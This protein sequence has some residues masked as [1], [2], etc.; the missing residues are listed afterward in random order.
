MSV[1]PGSKLAHYKI[2]EKIGSG[3]MGDV[4]LAEDTKLDRKVAL[5]VLPPELAESDERRARFKREAKAIA[6]LNHPNI[7]TIYSVEEAEGVHFLTME[8]V[9]G[10]TL[11]R[12]IPE[13]G[14][15]V[16]RLLDI[17]L[18]LADAV[19]AAHEQDIVHRD[20][21]PGNVMLSDRGQV[22]VFDFGLARIGKSKTPK[23]LDSDQST[24][25]ATRSGVVLGTVPYMSPEQLQG[26]TVDRRSD[27]FS[28]GAVLYQ[29]ATGRPP[30]VGASSAELIS[31]I[32]R[33]SP[34]MI[35]ELRSDVPPQL[36]RI[37]QR[38]LEK[39]TQDRFSTAFD[40][41][42]E[43]RALRLNRELDK[44][45]A[46]ATRS[47]LSPAVAAL[48]AAAL[49]GF[50]W[51][52]WSFLKAPP[53]A[54]ELPALTITPLTSIEGLSL[55]GSW[56][57]D[58]S[59]IAYDYTS[60]GTMDV[61]VM[62]LGGGEPRMV[63][64]GPNDEAMPRWSPDGSKIAFVSDDGTGMNI[65]WVPPTGGPWRTIAQTHLQYLD[66]FTALRAMGSQPWSRD[67]RRLVFSRLDPAGSA[68]LWQVDL[69]DGEQTRLTST[70]PGTNDWRAAWSHDGE[71]IAFQ[72]QEGGVPSSLYLIPAGGGE[73]H[74]LLVDGHD[75]GSPSWTADDRRVIFISDRTGGSDIHDVEVATETVRQ[76]TTGS[77]GSSPIGS[78]TARIAFSR[79]THQTYFYQM[80]LGS[81]DEH[82]Q[83]S[84]SKGNNF[85]QR[86]SPDGRS[87]VF[88][89]G[90]GGHSEIWLHDLETGA[91]RP[92]TNPPARIDDRTPDWSPDGT[93]VVFLSN[94]EGPFQLWVTSVDGGATRR[95]S[96][97]A[98]P[99][100]G[101][102]G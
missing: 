76:L 28:L 75:N 82:L 99:M 36:S 68:V 97:Q 32:L 16:E 87:I 88:Q 44:V 55:S 84:L 41:H 74:V 49:V 33:D 66:R 73:P 72:R 60:N 93:Q 78:S 15:E 48:G 3:G 29:M 22:K 27:I 56:S 42:Y 70:A 37:I 98:I 1:S 11:D 35:S 40:L 6:A 19:A 47:G 26:K 39:E 80:D 85:S 79:W 7:V 25:M 45:A 94:R 10:Q 62:S 30:F 34:S 77:G 14:L 38:C 54:A 31:S 20:L 69:E 9:Q 23:T 61:A 43:L 102:G 58:G 90:L 57:P 100:E 21:K 53:P 83:I 101:T 89:S 4:Y 17:A 64:G 63:A 71:W 91:E 65:Y 13:G 18:P 67:G 95:L 12:L 5:K 59:Q 52:G 2:L 46:T 96:E 81:S 86:F 50:L 92:L 51:G 8:L 24:D